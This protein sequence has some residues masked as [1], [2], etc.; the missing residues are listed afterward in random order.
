MIGVKSYCKQLMYNIKT[1]LFRAPTRG[2]GKDNAPG[3]YFEGNIR[4]VA[5][6]LLTIGSSNARG[7]VK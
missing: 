4:G 1:T 3:R 7:P 5:E 2:T 6:I